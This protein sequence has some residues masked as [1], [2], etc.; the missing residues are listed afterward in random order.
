MAIPSQAFAGTARR[1]YEKQIPYKRGGKDLRG[2]DSSGFIEYCLKQHGVTCSFSGTNDLYRELGP[3]CI[4]LKQA[5]RE[6]KVVPGAILLHVADDGGEPD[7]YKRDG[8]GNCDYAL[9]AISSTKGVYPSQKRGCMIETKIEPVRGKA[10]KVLLCKH[11]DYG[12]S[13]ESDSAGSSP[14]NDDVYTTAK[15]NMRKTPSL[16]GEKITSIPKGAEIKLLEYD[17][18]WS[19]VKYSERP[20]LWHIG[21]C[22]SEYLTL[23]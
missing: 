6:K 15:L 23:D 11:I 5:I 2:M 17:G 1:I 19:R 3:E 16:Q 21:W 4:P 20:G 9:I 10:N 8:L 14:S 13:G 22:A 7:K 12:F 18:E